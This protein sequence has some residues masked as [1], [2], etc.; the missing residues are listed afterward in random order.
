MA[1]F[2]T[3]VE[4]H[5]AT[6]SDYTKLHEAMRK[7]GF[8]LSIA[9]DDGKSYALP[10]A[11]YFYDGAIARSDVLNKA[12]SAAESVKRS[13]AAIVTEAAGTTWYGLKVA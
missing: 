8:R 6:W 1:W 7:Q 5:D 2:M 11:E 12:K 10:P 9:G 13:Y 4:L 3:R